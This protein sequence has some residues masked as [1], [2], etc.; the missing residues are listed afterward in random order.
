MTTKF[1]FNSVIREKPENKS[2][3]I[4]LMIKPTLKQA[5]LNM[6]CENNVKLSEFLTRILEDIVKGG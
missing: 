2:D 6:A 4:H 3:T 1:N 5:L